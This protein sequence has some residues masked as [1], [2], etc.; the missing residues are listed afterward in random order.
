MSALPVIDASAQLVL[1]GEDP[2]L[3]R[4]PAAAAAY[5]SGQPR[6]EPLAPPPERTD[7]LTYQ[8]LIDQQLG[9]TEVTPRVE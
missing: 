9:Y 7:P 1:D 8:D 4:L 6:P 2:G 3:V 5:V